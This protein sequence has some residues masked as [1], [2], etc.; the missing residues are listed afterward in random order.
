MG[1][2]RWILRMI[3]AHPA[4]LADGIAELGAGDGSLLRRLHRAHPDVPLSGYDLA[5][6]PVGLHPDTAWEAGDV[7]LKRGPFAAGVV[8]ANL[9]LHHFASEQIAR[10]GTRLERARMLLVCEPHRSPKV[11]RR[12]RVLVPFLGEVTRNDMEISLTAGFV[13][14]ELPDWLGLAGHVWQI[15]ESTSWFGCQ[16]LLAIRRDGTLRR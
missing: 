10:L 15:N 13:A 1:N 6:R 16:R 5:P 11:L 9:F 12:S 14:G 4:L 2:P 8:V 3:A 7:L